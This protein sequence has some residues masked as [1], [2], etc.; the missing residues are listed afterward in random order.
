MSSTK[1]LSYCAGPLKILTML[2]RPWAS[3]YQ[4]HLGGDQVTLP[5]VSTP[6]WLLSTTTNQ[7]EHPW[8]SLFPWEHHTWYA[9]VLKLKSAWNWLFTIVEFMSN[10]RGSQQDS[11]G[12][13]M[14]SLSDTRYGE[15]RGFNTLRLRQNGCHFPDDIFKC[16]SSNENIWILLKISLKFVPK[17]LINNIP[18]L[19]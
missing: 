10:K 1:C 6:H 8:H 14:G 9:R 17:G 5:L 11:M 19:V 3:K 4:L 12:S 7:L 18:A 15:V 16:I 13:K 2:F